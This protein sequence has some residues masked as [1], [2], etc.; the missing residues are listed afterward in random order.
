M[1]CVVR[2]AIDNTWRGNGDLDRVVCS[3]VDSQQDLS[4][5][6][7]VLLIFVDMALKSYSRS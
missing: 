7:K 4:K 3:E 5:Q 6:S 2:R 1:R